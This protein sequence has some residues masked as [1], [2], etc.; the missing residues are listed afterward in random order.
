MYVYPLDTAAGSGYSLLLLHA[1][2]YLLTVGAV[3]MILI[4][5]ILHYLQLLHVC[6]N[7]QICKI[8]LSNTILNNVQKGRD[9]SWFCGSTVR[10]LTTSN[11]KKLCCNW[12]RTVSETVF[13]LP[14]WTHIDNRYMSIT[15]H[16][17]V[18]ALS[19]KP[20]RGRLVRSLWRKKRQKCCQVGW[21]VF[22]D[23][24]IWE[25]CKRASDSGSTLLSNLVF[26]ALN[27]GQQLNAR[28]R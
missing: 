6:T 3:H 13:C 4:E 26:I 17:N 28:K 12:L 14:L 19:P 1:L 10:I 20:E 5:C 23:E 21:E 11:C 15:E 27:K 7:L 22:L 9:S 25:R 24:T 2:R 18:Q 16:T 8:F